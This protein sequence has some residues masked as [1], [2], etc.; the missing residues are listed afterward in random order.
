VEALATIDGQE[1]KNLGHGGRELKNAAMEFVEDSRKGA[2]NKQMQT[3]LEALKARNAMLEQDVETLKNSRIDPEFQ[4]MTA[5]QLRDY[6]TAQT[7]HAPHGTANRKTLLQMAMT[8]RPDK[9][10]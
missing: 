7:G 3:E 8:C 5:E 10:A 6:V 9:V 4:D 1:L 2:P